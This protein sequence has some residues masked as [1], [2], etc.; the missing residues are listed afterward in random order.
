MPLNI[1]RCG[2]GGDSEAECFEA[3]KR[4]DKN[5]KVILIV[6]DQYSYM[7]EKK[8]S[9]IFGGT[10]LNN[11]FVYTFRQMRRSFLNVGNPRYL[12]AS[13]KN[14][15]LKYVV[16]NTVKEDSIFYAGRMGQGFLDNI[17]NLICEFKRYC[18][19]PDMLYRSGEE[20]KN[21]QLKNKL[22][23]IADIYGEFQKKLDEGNF[24]D[25]ED[26]L[27]R[28]ADEL[29]KNQYFC[30]SNVWV[31]MFT[32]FSPQ[33]IRVLTAILK[34]GAN[35]TIYLPAKE[36][37]ENTE[38]SLFSFPEKT[39]ND[40]KK[41][42]EKEKLLYREF[43]CTRKRDMK[44]AIK[45]FSEN[46][47]N[48]DFKY[49][50]QADE[51]RIFRAKEKYSEVQETAL[52]ILDLV[53]EDG[54]K[55]SDIALI[56]TELQEY[57]SFIEPVFFEYHI[58]YFS[59]F[60]V[61]MSEQSIAVLIT[62]L[63]D[64]LNE[65]S[66]TKEACMRY[67]RTGFLVSDNDADIIENYIT[68]CGIRG[69]MWKNPKYWEGEK[70]VFD[71]VTVER[72]NKSNENLE[73]LREKIIE[74]ILKFEEKTKGKKTVREHCT[75]FFEYLNDIELF[76]KISALIKKFNETKRENEALRFEQ[77]WNFLVEITEQA[78]TVLGDVALSRDEFYELFASGMTACEISIIPSVT[79]GVAVSDLTRG[80]KDEVKALFILGATK[81][82]L[83]KMI[84]DEG[85]LTDADREETKLLLAPTREKADEAEEFKAVKLL[86]MPKELL[87]L[88]YPVTDI[89]GAVC[90]PSQFILDMEE[91]FPKAD[92][93]DNLTSDNELLYI[94]SPEATIH[95]LLLKMA[96]EN[97]LN[98]LWE[99]VRRWYK[100]DGKWQDKLRIIDAVSEYRSTGAKLSSEAA[101]CLYKDYDNYSISRIEKYF[102]CPFGYF[103]NNGLRL[104]ECKEWEIGSTDTGSLLHWAVCEYCKRVDGDAENAKEKKASWNA[105][106]KEESE[107]IV[108]DIIRSAEEKIDFPEYA[109]G[110]TKNVLKRVEKALKKSV[111]IVNLSM[112]NGKYTGAAYEVEFSEKE[113]K[114]SDGSVKIK[115]IIDRI[116]VYEDEENG[117]AYIRII[118]YKTG[119][120]AYST[121]R[122]LNRVDLQ[123]AVY[124][125][126][127]TEMYKNGEIPKTSGKLE[128]QVSGIYYDKI[129][130]NLVE[131]NSAI[132]ATDVWISSS[133]LDGT[134]FS[135]ELG[136]GKNKYFD[137]VDAE[138]MDYEI[139]QNGESRFLKLKKKEKGVGMDRKKSA[140]ESIEVR[141]AM[142]TLVKNSLIEADIK[143]KSGDIEVS[144]YKRTSPK[145]S[146][147]KYC[148]YKQICAP[149]REKGSLKKRERTQKEILEEILG[150]EGK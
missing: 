72:H 123:L 102:E 144:P 48:P 84:S 5:E 15:L 35:V 136:K 17:K 122:V 29:Y 10:G 147:C 124:A 134:M 95:K 74:P 63:F 88:S 61:L 47:E 87:S 70:K 6:P 53:R 58:P 82:T 93:D 75:A 41:V 149:D 44:P 103:L 30:N 57:I 85:L 21:S 80:A 117:K 45:S 1:V 110:K 3:M 150:G 38:D 139:E 98:P 37:K 36:N 128:P 114:N 91:S 19:T 51:I 137:T 111:E 18:I 25:S 13:G 90:E 145:D 141:D 52:K 43:V 69:N 8:M 67:L 16:K 77:V 34:S 76:E 79:D 132:G 40:L 73:K 142:L 49:N 120:K 115:G 140:V 100:K 109:I 118:D 54:F 28:L 96:D 99:A 126:A 26:D 146:A 31:D 9:D 135:E 116:D 97:A 22:I 143:I 71:D 81:N 86:T 12:S 131:S 89:S 4:A 130:K 112:K 148:P 59:D 125:I 55:F 42:C 129:N 39:V 62:S 46:F 23:S 56:C 101:L 119:K 104:N 50:R 65:N 138:N 105:L 20:I 7:A 121:E 64:M 2:L 27:L 113:I 66:F 94:S 11:R 133:K 32:D 60:K 107:S 24:L 108:S 78:V 83:P 106:T 33:H 92:L 14:M 68:K 127:A